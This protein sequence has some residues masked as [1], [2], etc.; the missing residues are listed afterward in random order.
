MKKNIQYH[1]ALGT[2]HY[3]HLLQHSNKMSNSFVDTFFIFHPDD[4]VQ[5]TPS[6]SLL[7]SKL[8]QQLGP[9]QKPTYSYQFNQIGQ[10]GTEYSG[11]DN[12]RFYFASDV[13]VSQWHN[14]ILV[15]DCGNKRIQFFDLHSKEYRHTLKVF[16]SPV[17]MCIDGD[18]DLY[19]TTRNDKVL[20]YNI[21]EQ[22]STSNHSPV[23][24]SRFNGKFLNG[25]AMYHHGK[26]PRGNSSC[27]FAGNEGFGIP[28]DDDD[29]YDNNKSTLFVCDTGNNRVVKLNPIDG[30]LV[31]TFSSI[32]IVKLIDPL[33]LAFNDVGECFITTCN[34]VLCIRD[35]ELVK[36]FTVEEE[37]NSKIWLNITIDRD[38]IIISCKASN[39]LVVRH[40]FDYSFSLRHTCRPYGLSGCCLNVHSGELLVV[41]DLGV[42]LYN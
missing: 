7:L 22:L 26:S 40:R 4:A 8:K 14:L 25:I 9:Q 39:T 36:I 3:I 6:I 41:D 42:L 18:D 24:T 20:K 2:F 11:G 12:Q 10:L 15:C 37:V 34:T 31:S 27:E 16:A 35:D 21:K 23:W 30:T 33:S 29:Y 13:K 28:F 1:D 32:G 38:F 17:R 19:V 5:S